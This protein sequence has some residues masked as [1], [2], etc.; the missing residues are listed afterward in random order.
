LVWYTK[1]SHMI[2]STTD[3]FNS[4]TD[5]DLKI[6]LQPII[7]ILQELNVLNTF[8]KILLTCKGKYWSLVCPR[9][10]WPHLFLPHVYKFPSVV[11]AAIWNTLLYTDLTLVSV[12]YW[13]LPNK[14]GGIGVGS[15]LWFISGPLPRIP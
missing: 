2:N 8:L 9:P 14:I 15:R 6:I 11:I 10:N 5:R 1:R 13:F 3:T 7:I 12:L 4:S